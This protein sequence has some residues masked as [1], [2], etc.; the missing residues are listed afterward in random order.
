[1]AHLPLLPQEHG[2]NANGKPT[3]N[4]QGPAHAVIHGSLRKLPDFV[5]VTRGPGM[6]VN[7]TTGLDTAKGLAVAWQVPLYG[8]HHMQAH[9]LTPRL[10]TAL[11]SFTHFD[12]VAPRFPFLSLLVSGGH[13]LLLHTK[14]ITDH[15]ILAETSDIAIGD[16][17]DKIA[18]TILPA[19]LARSSTNGS[20]GSLLE[21][22]AFPAPKEEAQPIHYDYQPPR[23]RYDVELRSQLES[24]YGWNCPSPLH[25][26]RGGTKKDAMEF[27]FAGLVTYANRVAQF[28][29][30]VV[31]GKLG[32]TAREIPMGEVEA[33]LLARETMRVAFEHLAGRVVLA[34]ESE[35]KNQTEA[36]W[37]KTLVIS[38]GV[39]AN[40]FLRYLMREYLKAR[41]FPDVE[42]CVPPPDLCTDNA[43]MIAWAG[44]EMHEAGHRDSALRTRALRKWSLENILHPERE[45][46]ARATGG[47]PVSTKDLVMES[48]EG[49]FSLPHEEDIPVEQDEKVHASDPTGRLYQ[50]ERMG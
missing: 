23:S 6:R 49:G 7:L 39:A 17:L 12:E 26:S 15:S 13:T 50:T 45:D 37:S 41:G 35:R 44:Y 32:K 27:S 10:M 14:S 36:D 19:E 29:F 40:R 31:R 18:R 20:F 9:V 30:N 46:D 28:G 3:D 47:D 21:R 34:L 16:C 25:N 1:M 38:G 2:L 48:A 8:V 5:V 11:Q 43:A 22:F 42:I 33:R 24:P 4:E